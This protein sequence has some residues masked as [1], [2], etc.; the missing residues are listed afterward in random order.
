MTGTMS[1]V[2]LSEAVVKLPA[3]AG[4]GG[5][6]DDGGARAAAA[7]YCVNA[8][9]LYA[10]SRQNAFVAPPPG[11]LE[12]RVCLQQYVALGYV[13]KLVALLSASLG[14]P[15][16]YNI[17]VQA[18]RLLQTAAGGKACVLAASRANL[19]SVQLRLD[20]RGASKC[21]R[22]RSSSSCCAGGEALW[23]TRLGCW[24]SWRPEA[25]E[26]SAFA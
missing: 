18:L 16:R 9:G 26:P 3:C 22:S 4:T 12:G 1:D 7:G 11:V 10:A 8:S 19:P 24:R 14:K 2:T 13:P 21:S 20:A 5:A 17:G 15:A 6:R 23:Q 25:V